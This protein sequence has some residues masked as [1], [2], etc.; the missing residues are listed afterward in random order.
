MPIMNGYEATKAIRNLEGDYYKKIPI[1]A[2]SANAYSEDVATCLE[3]GMNTHIAK[4]FNPVELI[5]TLQ[6]YIG[7]LE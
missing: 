6:K 2:M 5:K 1:I 4:P 3:A 7:G